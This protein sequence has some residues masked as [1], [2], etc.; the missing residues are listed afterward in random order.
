MK[1]K[2]IGFAVLLA[3]AGC[4]SPI[5]DML[6]NKFVSIT[7][8][9]APESLVGVWSGNMGPYLASFS[10]K[11]AG[12]GIF[13]YSW[14]T[15]DVIQKVKYSNNII[16]IQDGSKLEIKE[17]N[18]D[19]LVVNANYLGGNKST[20]YKDKD[21]KEASQYCANKLRG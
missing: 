14:G 10:F 9:V 5:N 19:L 12:Y 18:N 11:G 1:I 4:A 3:L 2:V 20:F 16:Y 15:A 8:Q 6:N 21:L 7:P 17:S 13:C